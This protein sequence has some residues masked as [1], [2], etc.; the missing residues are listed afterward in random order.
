MQTIIIVNRTSKFN[1]KIISVLIY[2]AS[3]NYFLLFSKQIFL[4]SDGE[5]RGYI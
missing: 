5:L 3:L 1:D 2:Q 4:Y